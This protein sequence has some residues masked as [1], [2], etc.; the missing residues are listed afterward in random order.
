MESTNHYLR[1]IG[2][3][4]L[5][6]FM[7]MWAYAQT[8]SVQ[9]IVKDP[10]GE[11]IIGASV[12]EPGT[13][14]GTMTD[15][16]GNYSIQV[17][18]Q[19]KLTVSFIGYQPQA[20][21]VSGRNRI[22][23]VL[24]EDNKLL[25]EVVVI[26]YGTQRRQDVTGSIASM[27]GDIMREMQ[28]S[29]ISQSLQGRIAGVEMTQTSSQ[30]GANMQIR[31]RGTRSLT[32]S[33]DPLII[34]DG[35]PFMG[36]L[37]DVNPNDIKS[38][39]IL[40]D[41]SSTAIYGSRG[42]NGV[43]MISTYK[44]ESVAYD[45]PVVN[46]NAYYGVKSL[47]NEYPMMNASEFTAWREEAIKN[48]ASWQYGVDEDKSLNTN[49][50]DLVFESAMV[51]SHDLNVSGVTKGGGYS[52]GVGYYDETSVLPGQEFERFSLR[53]SFDQQIGRHFK[54]GINTMNSYG[55][56]DGGQ[57]NPLGSILSLTPLTNPYNTDGSIK[58]GEMYINNMDVYYNPMM[59][60]SLGDRWKDRRRTFASYNSLYGEVM[61]IDG[62]RYRLNLGL[63]FRQNDYGNYKGAE[64]PFNASKTSNGTIENAQTTNWTIENL[65]YYDKTINEKHKIGLVAM[66]SAEQTESS[67][68][69]AYAEDIT[70][71][72]VQHYNFGL[73]GDNGKVTFDP[74][75][76]IYYKRGL[77]SAMFR[78]M[79]SYDD[80]YMLTAT[81]RTDGS[82]VLSDGHK[83]HTYPA[84]SAGWNITGEDFMKDVKWLD[85]LKLRIGYGQTSNQAIQPYQTLGGLSTNYYNF[86][87]RNV[88]GYYVSTLPNYSLGWEYSTT[89]NY[90][91]DFTLFNHRLSGT[92]EYYT[93]NTHDVLVAQSLPQSSGVTGTFM[94]NMGETRNRG[95]ELSLNATILKDY[96]GWNWD[97]GF[98]VYANRNKIL[99]LA[100]GQLYDKGNGWFVGQPID[101]IYDFKKIGIWQQ[102]EENEVV[103]YEGSTGQ[104]GMIKIEYTGD[105]DANGNPIR[106][107]Q[108]GTTL[109]D[110]DRQILGSIEPDFQGGFNTRVGYKGFDLSIIGSY[111]SGGLLVSSLH[112]QT[113]YL[114][115]NSGRRGQ[116]QIDYW[117][118]DNPTNAYPKPYGP[119]VTN[120]P[121][122]ASTLSYFD[123]SYVKITNITL[124]YNF[125]GKWMQKLGVN[126]L[127][128]YA[129]VQNPFIFASDYYS[130]TGL[131]PQP[132]ADG[133]NG[134]TQAVASNSV[135]P[136]RIAVVGYNTPATRNYLFGLNVSF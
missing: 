44:G 131:D 122:Y 58:T 80:K 60:E 107:I 40:K 54:F 22:D 59:I 65:L 38:L 23:I 126:K 129:T 135:L 127:R 79:Y 130:E 37:S 45:R 33:N 83:W 92:F 98:N 66:Y 116:I 117:T 13:T 34:L 120:N 81:L 121:K 88:S 113:S 15:I 61:I 63:N 47:L 100:S 84:V 74:E 85:F 6:S 103:K 69:N 96:N 25:D 41:A 73:L 99:S 114:N 48:G 115:M 29:N 125:S 20:I 31:I 57:D 72:A 110:D 11:P 42:A 28:S 101:A 21:D 52:F 102:G 132:N 19:G 27:R 12:V 87:D 82:S 123:A 118:Q 14:N 7:S 24:D 30:P 109:D 4:F 49:W 9:G 68:S 95:V 91:I 75:K 43:I 32:G 86:G 90:G 64:T 39:D 97:V 8:I 36:S 16:D 71:D 136:S 5:F 67:V 112:S 134:S 3:F 78:A 62:L 128:V 53:G 119:E 111:K 18:S 76:Q 26:G 46:Y 51:T 1:T 2:L 93:Q 55:I 56:I 108:Q 10:T 17:S 89:W 77:L 35:I 94:T 70:S 106:Q 124:G 105:Y 50:Q 104:V 133:G